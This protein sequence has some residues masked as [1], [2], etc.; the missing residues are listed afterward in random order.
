MVTIRDVADLAQVSATTVSHVINQTRH[1][2]PATRQRVTEAIAELGYRPNTLARSLR[3]RETRTIGLIVPDNSN[4]YFAELARAVEDAGFAKGY[5]VIL[6]NS[7]MSEVKEAAYIEAL[8][9][10]Q[11]DGIILISAA[12]RREK[13]SEI[14]QAG[15]PVVTVARELSDLPIDQIVTDNEQGGYLVGRHLIELGHRRIGCIAGPRDETPSADRIV[16]LRR[17]LHEA[18]IDLPEG[19]VIRGD[20]TYESGHRV[21]AEL[22]LRSPD[23]TAVFAANDRMA[24]GAMNYLWQ[25][26]RR[27]PDDISIIGFDDIPVAAMTCPPLTTI[28][29]PKA[30]FARVSVSLLIERITNARREPVRVILPTRLVVRESCRAIV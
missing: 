2:D 29:T 13:F 10:K 3:R 21:M 20:F 23:L 17:A 11:V 7:D 5:S 30:D 14:I 8:L 16:G 22:L 1:V 18:G 27:I 12:N 26:G 15:V 19:L 24:V 9:S 28:A 6:C 4:P 25:T